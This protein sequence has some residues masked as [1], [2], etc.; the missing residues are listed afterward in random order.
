MQILIKEILLGVLVDGSFFLS[1]LTVGAAVAEYRYSKW[2]GVSVFVLGLT[3]LVF[4][5]FYNMHYATVVAQIGPQ[6]AL[7]ALGIAAS[8]SAAIE[9]VN[10]GLYFAAFALLIAGTIAWPAGRATVVLS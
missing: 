4:A 5:V 10:V 8:S 2:I 7:G 1:M 3:E 9:S 6:N